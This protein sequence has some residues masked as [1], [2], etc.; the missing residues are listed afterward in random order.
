MKQQNSFH[1][2][3]ILFHYY[4]FTLVLSFHL[5]LC[6]PSILLPSGCST[7]ILYE[8]VLSVMCAH[9]I[10]STKFW[11]SSKYQNYSNAARQF[12][13]GNVR[14]IGRT[15]CLL[16]KPLLSEEKGDIQLHGDVSLPHFDSGTVRSTYLRLRIVI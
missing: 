3:S 10:L 15:L 5:F 6:L 13:G 1:T 2:H 9:L 16:I 12:R 14:T 4:S 7:K 11:G 8:F